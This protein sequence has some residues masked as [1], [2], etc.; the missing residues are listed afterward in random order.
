MKHTARVHECY[1]K[2]SEGSRK[3]CKVCGGEFANSALLKKHL[4]VSHSD[5]S[6]D[7]TCSQCGDTFYDK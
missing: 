7:H 1:R 3:R 5:R 2:A 6:K 4:T